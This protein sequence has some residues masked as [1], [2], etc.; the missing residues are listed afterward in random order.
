MAC[1]RSCACDPSS[2]SPNQSCQQRKTMLKT[3]WNNFEKE[4]GGRW[5]FY[6]VVLWLAAIWSKKGRFSFGNVSTFLQP[7][8]AFTMSTCDISKQ[9]LNNLAYTLGASYLG[10]YPWGARQVFIVTR[11]P[12]RGFAARVI[13][14]RRPPWSISPALAVSSK[15]P[16]VLGVLHI[17]EP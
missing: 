3:K 14:L 13:G 11:A 9:R 16:P 10:H 6:R 17:N 12:L 2:S 4:G 15:K 1:P 8:V 5:V 7:V